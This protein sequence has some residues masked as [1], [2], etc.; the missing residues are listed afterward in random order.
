MEN[1]NYAVIRELVEIVFNDEDL[2]IFCY[3][4]FSD[5]ERRFTTGQ[6]Q[7]ARVQLLIDHVRRHGFTNKLLSEI[8]KSNPYQYEKF[9]SRLKDSQ[10]EIVWDSAELKGG[11]HSQTHGTVIAENVDSIKKYYYKAPDNSEKKKVFISYAREDIE[12]AERLY[13]D[14]EKAGLKPWMDEKDLLPGQNWELTVTNAIKESSYF[15]ALLSE[16][17][18]SKKGYVQKKLKMA[19]DILAEFP[20]SEI[21]L[22]PLRLN[23]CHPL[24][25][26]L[27]EIS[28][29]GLF[30]SYDD[31]FKDVMRVLESEK[32]PEKKQREKPVQKRKPGL[33]RWKTA[34]LSLLL[35][36]VI[37]FVFWPEPKPDMQEPAKK[38]IP[39]P[40]KTQPVPESLQEETPEKPAKT[41]K[42]EQTIT[43]SVGMMFAYI[44]PGTFTMGSP[45]TEKGRDSDEKQHKVT[46]TKGF[47]MQ[48]T[49][50]TVGQW[51]AFVKDTGYNTDAEKEGWAWGYKAGSWGKQKGYH[52]YNPGFIQADT[53]PVT[54]VSWNDAQAFINWLNKKEGEAY[55]LPTE[56]EW[57]YSCRAGTDTAY[58]FGSDSSQLGEYA[59]YWNNSGQ[60]THPVAKKKPNKWVLYDMH[61][62]VWE[63]CQDYY[64]ASYPF[65]PVTDPVKKK[66]SNRVLRGGSWGGNAQ[67]CRSARRIR[68]ASGNSRIIVGFRLSGDKDMIHN[69]HPHTFVRKN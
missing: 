7:R 45:E 35:I 8:R 39:E 21:F 33:L 26:A 27:Q 54:C 44:R 67:Y 11:I 32:P 5:V 66:G 53:H 15:L 69:V 57:E 42:P 43:N 19:L 12:V 64:Y 2:K 50:V 56:A 38:V 3:D 20:K 14:L 16:N 18:V 36:C 52:W 41:D 47:Y 10:T 63:W 31:G 4:H 23:N 60:K 59:W 13:H 29:G 24:D 48:T 22:L 49:E 25:E 37:A 1:Y 46:L 17:S 34:V 30:P 55:R 9:E 28:W 65:S 58:Y 40:V 62:N 61:G 68:D 6:T 51:R